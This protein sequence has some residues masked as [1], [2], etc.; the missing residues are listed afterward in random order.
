M[1]KEEVGGVGIILNFMGFW[2]YPF[3]GHLG[4]VTVTN[5]PFLI[6]FTQFVCFGAISIAQVHVIGVVRRSGES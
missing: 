1:E 3:A 2:L 4:V 6:N 5:S